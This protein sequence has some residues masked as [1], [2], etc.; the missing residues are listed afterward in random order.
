MSCPYRSAD[1]PIAD[2]VLDK[3]TMLYPNHTV[4]THLGCV[5]IRICLGL[6]LLNSDLGTVH[7][8]A[9]VCLFVAILLMFTVK[10]MTTKNVWKCYPR[11]LLAYSAGLV[12]LA[13]GAPSNAGILV[14]VDAL[15]GVQSRSSAHIAS[16]IAKCP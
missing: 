1:Q 4:Y 8:K 2:V 11:T 12:S 5:L 14:I 16:V 6:V 3:T 7:K 13:R 10:Y 15:L 9:F